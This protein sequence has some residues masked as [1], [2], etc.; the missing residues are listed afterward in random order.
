MI[1]ENKNIWV[2]YL[3][4]TKLMSNTHGAKMQSGQSTN[5]DG[6]LYI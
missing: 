2:L 4:Q 6:E 1:K 5:W 3:M